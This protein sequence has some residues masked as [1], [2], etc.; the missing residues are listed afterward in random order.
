G[1]QPLQEITAAMAE[2]DAA[3]AAAEKL[4]PA[5]GAGPAE[6]SESERRLL[7]QLFQ[8]AP[9]ALFL[10]D[11]DGAIRRANA[12]AGRLI[13]TQ[14]RSATGRLLTAFVDVPARAA[15]ATQLATAA[16]TGRQQHLRARVLGP[17]GPFDAIFT[18]APLTAEDQQLLLVAIGRDMRAAGAAGRGAGKWRRGAGP[19]GAGS[20]TRPPEPGGAEPDG[21]EPG[22]AEG[23]T[24][25]QDAAAAAAGLAGNGNAP[26]DT[27][28]VL[29]T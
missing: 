10:L 13:G 16:R 21:A 15:A 18:I 29:D 12:R 27:E 9:V 6:S 3:I 4:R 7:G 17:D 19:A 5:A 2:L 8:Q 23:A 28:A 22:G 1:A 26:L 14:A 25:D 24:A 11:R 20:G